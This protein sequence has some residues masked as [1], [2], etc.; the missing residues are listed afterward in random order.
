MNM[1]D[2]F[3]KPNFRTLTTIYTLNYLKEYVILKLV[4][5]NK[6]Y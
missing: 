6:L 3:N 1:N 2:P 4:I 5:F